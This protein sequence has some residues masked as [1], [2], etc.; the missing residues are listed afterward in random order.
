MRTRVVTRVVFVLAVAMIC[1]AVSSA[2]AQT[3]VWVDDCAGTG[4]GTQGD[5]YC[6]IQTAI[7]NI[8]ATGGT[9]QV[10]PGVYHEAI[11]FPANVTVISTDG[12]AVT[13]I[14]A[15]GRP[16]VVNDFCTFQGTTNCSAV[17][18]PS[19]AGTTSRLEGFHVQGG[20]GTDQ[21]GFL[22]KIGAG[23]LV[24]GSSPT[25]TRNE[26]VGNALSSSTYKIFYGGGIYVNG[27]D[28]LNPPRPV[29]TNNLIQGNSADPAAGTSSKP[30]EGDGGGIYVGY[31]SAPIIETNTIKS[32]LAGAGMSNEY[33]SGGGIALYSRVTVQDAKI[34]GNLIT[35]NTAR[36]Y[37]GGIGAGEYGTP[38]QASR[39]TVSNNVIEAN[40]GFNGGGIATATTRVKFYNNTLNN[41]T[42]PGGLGGGAY[43]HVPATV[44][45]QA[46]MVNNLLTFG[47][48]SG[49]GQGGG[50]YV[51]TGANPT[52][53]FNDIY[54]NTPTNVGG[55]KTDADYIGVNGGISVDPLYVNRNGTPPNYH[56]LIGSPV[57]EVGDNTVAT[58][59]TDYDGAP[60]VQDKDYNGTFV[61]DMGAFEFQP[62]Y[63]GD[64]TADWQDTDDDGDGV[65]DASDCAP[66][67]RAVSQ[68]AG[69]VGNSLRVEKNGDV[70]WPHSLQGH[71]YNV[72]KGTFG[73][74]SPFA[75]NE[76]CQD[77]ERVSR[78]WN[79][80]TIPAAGTGFYYLVSAKNSCGESAATGGHAAQ[81][82]CASANRNSDADVHLDPADNCPT[83]SNVTQSDVDGDSAGDACDVCASVANVDQADGDGDAVGDTC[84]NCVSVANANQANADLDALGDACDPDDDNDGALDASDNCPLVANP[85]QTDTDLDGRGDACDN[86]PTVSNASQTD[87][88]GDGRGDVCD[89][90]PTVSNASQTDG[91]ADGRGDVCDN[92][93]TVSNASQTDGDAD[94]PG[95]ACDNC[96][97]VSNANQWD[98][99]DDGQ[100]DACDTLCTLTFV[101]SSTLDG[102][103]DSTPSATG[104]VTP[105][106]IGDARVGGSQ[107]TYRAVLSFDTS[108][109]PDAAIVTSSGANLTT[110]RITRQSLSGSPSALGSLVAYGKNGF[111][112]AASSVQTD[113]YAAAA[114]G[115]FAQAFTIPASNDAS[116]TISFSASE[117]AVVNLT[118]LTQFRLQFTSLNNGNTTADQLLIYSG[119][120]T[121][122]QPQ[123]TV[124]YTAP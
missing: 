40:S 94:G 112:G 6:K 74:G 77:N 51:F 70:S 59:A 76:S 86:C 58:F 97:A 93:P 72:Y 7:C 26:I 103:V 55:A 83:T 99:D 34:N 13:T 56:L 24:Y 80:A 46:E 73:G 122:N 9:V 49:A 19:A 111:L 1:A 23:V 11:R 20:G 64:G 60:R 107:V 96:A 79:D 113:D 2:R 98:C 61:V 85:T 90:C 43:I 108:A 48:A 88:D 35:G 54:G 102:Q 42:A 4:T 37:G 50:I 101:S 117:T 5:P 27:I 10:L 53:R 100:G 92:C 68:P 110:L 33:G 21:P 12:P 62:D 115:P 75:Y 15:A 78:L 71:T 81:N 14:D 45:E 52:V 41:N 105:V 95:D 106:K 119:K 66:L 121:S 29:I 3:T 84:D 17:Y 30:S 118:G 63:D 28:A 104:G 38:V 69:A 109:L 8:Q 32:N 91:D 87:G 82:A 47:Q 22:A 18:F 31:N 44:G 123:L 67:T 89:N 39:G 16:C 114:T 120:A 57:A 124:K 116:S 36:D 25:I 65:A